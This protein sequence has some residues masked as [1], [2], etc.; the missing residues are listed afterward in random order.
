M[1]TEFRNLKEIGI[2]LN[3]DKPDSPALAEKCISYLIR[4]GFKVA[5]LE[6]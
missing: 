5:L 6:G 4:C 3:M 1:E 2:Y